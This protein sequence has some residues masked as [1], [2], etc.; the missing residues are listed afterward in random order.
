MAAATVA[1]SVAVRLL[2]DPVLHEHEP[3]IMFF[4]AVAFAA[5]IGGRGP[6]LLALLLGA[7]AVVWF[8]FEPRGTWLILRPEMQL[9]LVLYV[10]VGCALIALIET[11]RRN[12][13]QL[14][15]TLA[16]I[17]DAVITTDADG[18]ICLIRRSPSRPSFSASV[19]SMNTRFGRHFS[20]S[21]MPS[22]ALP[23][24]RTS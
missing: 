7:V 2:L 15:T 5:W 10:L 3:Y 18:S 13:E 9:G 21:A 8:L 12:Q 23:A 14:R 17:G 4:P 1:A 6:G 16:S 11:L 24:V 19:T 22:V 20:Y